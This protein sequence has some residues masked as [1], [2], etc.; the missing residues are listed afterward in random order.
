MRNKKL[1][2]FFQM[3]PFE[4]LNEGSDSTISIIREGLKVDFHYREIFH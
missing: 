4:K 3:D 1:S 2:A